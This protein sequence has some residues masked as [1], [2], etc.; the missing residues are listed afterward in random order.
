MH[1]FSVWAPNAKEIRLVGSFNN[2][3]GADYPLIK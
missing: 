2:W 3:N 1:D